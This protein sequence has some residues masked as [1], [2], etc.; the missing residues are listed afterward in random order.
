M[1]DRMKRRGAA[2]LYARFFGILCYKA[3][4]VPFIGPFK[5][6]LFLAQILL[7]CLQSIVLLNF[8]SLTMHLLLLVPSKLI[9]PI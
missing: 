5:K 8:A 6:S 4:K 1:G 9:V 2:P 7:Q 3:L